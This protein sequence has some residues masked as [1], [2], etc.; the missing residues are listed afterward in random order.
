MKKVASKAMLLLL[1][2]PVNLRK[3]CAERE[4]PSSSVGGHHAFSTSQAGEI[5]LAKRATVAAGRGAAAVDGYHKGQASVFFPS[6]AMLMAA[7]P[8][9]FHSSTHSR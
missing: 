6:T 8:H 2:P 1:G 4:N 5:F 9:S 7:K 3:P